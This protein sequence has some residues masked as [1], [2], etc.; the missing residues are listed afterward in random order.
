M[1]CGHVKE[2]GNSKLELKLEQKQSQILS[3]MMIQSMAVLQMGSQELL[4]FVEQTV[5]ENPVLEAEE[6]F[7]RQREAGD[8]GDLLQRKL[9]WLES[10]D[11][12]NSFYYRQDDEDRPLDPFGASMDWED[13]LYGHLLFQLQGMDLKEDVRAAC[14]FL[15]ESLDGNGWLDEPLEVLVQDS[16]RPLSIL[17][18]G[19]QLI[20][21]LDPAGVGARSLS[22]CLSLQLLREHPQD[23]LALRIVRDGLEALARNQYGLLA[24]RMSAAP[25]AVR[26]ACDHIRSLNP[27]PGAGFTVRE[28]PSYITPDLV[29]VRQYDH[30]EVIPNDRFFPSLHLNHTYTQMLQEHPEPEVQDYL[31]GKVRQAK[32]VIGAIEQRRST[33]LSCARCILKAQEAFF[34]LGPSHLA[35]LLLSDVAAEMGVHESTVSRAIKD[36]Y[37]QCD[38]GVYPLYYF[39]SRKLGEEGEEGVSPSAAKALLRR[40]VDE[41]DKRRPL[42]DQKL[43]ER[44][45][46][47]GCRLSRRTVAKYREELG[48]PNTSGRK[49][50]D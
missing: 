27:R 10:S 47:E 1:I 49:Q 25:A 41:E 14:I 21:S 23:L 48:I 2:W 4:D 12:Q 13:T 19:L 15:A 50:Y 30:F 20:Q 37:L 16:G 29:V 40:L 32:W 46:E 22:E 43:C 39:F 11:R 17:E 7:E 24:R 38:Q 42:S 8:A 45:A 35:P 28:A 33:L 36:K 26:A 9:E 34:R 44:M 6:H 31:S 5:Q 3:P 18:E